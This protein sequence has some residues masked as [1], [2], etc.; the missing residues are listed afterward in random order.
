MN[1]KKYEEPIVR[2]FYACIDILAASAGL[3]DDTII[4]ADE[5]FG[6]TKGL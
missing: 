5:I 3:D 6:G 2:M 4:G 1:K